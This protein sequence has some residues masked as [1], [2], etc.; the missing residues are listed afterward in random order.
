MSICPPEISGKIETYLDKMGNRFYSP[1][2]FELHVDLI[3]D[4]T[5]TLLK[6]NKDGS[7]C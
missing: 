2:D 7:I 3:E 5:I 6:E 4:P 1:E